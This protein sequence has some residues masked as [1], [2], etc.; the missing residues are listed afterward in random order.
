MFR[1]TGVTVRWFYLWSPGEQKESA[2]IS[3]KIAEW[4]WEHTEWLPI[5]T[6]ICKYNFSYHKSTCFSMD[7]SSWKTRN[8]GVFIIGSVT[9]KKKNIRD[10][11]FEDCKITNII[12]MTA[13]IEELREK[14]I[15]NS[16]W[17]F[18]KFEELLVQQVWNLT[19][20]HNRSLKKCVLFKTRFLYLLN[21]K[22]PLPRPP[23]P[24]LILNDFR[25]WPWITLKFSRLFLSHPN[26]Q[27]DTWKA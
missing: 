8:W 25:R 23:P 1:H 12:T 19:W 2:N 11:R 10:Y 14:I 20:Y 17:L 18:A 24:P 6:F 13:C 5:M 4:I 9:H 22:S 15:S 26:L 3:K 27:V 21:S 16:C 7:L